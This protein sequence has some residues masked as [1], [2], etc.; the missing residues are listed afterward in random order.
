MGDVSNYGTSE[1]GDLQVI[2]NGGANWMA[3]MNAFYD[4]KE[5]AQ[6]AIVKAGIVGDVVA[7]LD[8]AK[9]EREAASKA[10]ADARA[11]ADG[12]VSGAEKQADEILTKAKA[13]AARI[14]AEAQGVADGL[15]LNATKTNEAAEAKMSEA[16]AAMGQCAAR[17]QDLDKRELAVASREKKLDA[18]LKD[19]AA[20]KAAYK[21][22]VK[23]LRSVFDQEPQSAT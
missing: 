15:Q 22:L 16:N 8:E 6:A 7:H 21:T 13:E 23:K 17:E 20:T 10:L 12:I 14:V 9:A 18:A 1:S 2:M 3:R 5:K 11:F 19:A 4:A